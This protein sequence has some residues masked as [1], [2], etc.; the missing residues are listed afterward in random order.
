MTIDFNGKR[1]IAKG[2]VVTVT[3]SNGGEITAAL[4]QNHYPTYDV[5]LDGYVIPSFRVV[6][7][8]EQE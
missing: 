6:S 7:V 4:A 3:T 5:A 8:T 1:I 2:T